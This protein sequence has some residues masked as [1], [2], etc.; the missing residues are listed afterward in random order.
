MR[1]FTDISPMWRI[2]ALTEVFGPSGFG[3]KTEIVD[4]TTQPGPSGDLMCFMTINLYV[5][6]DWEN[7]ES[8]WSDPILGFG[9][10]FLIVKES[11][12]TRSDDEG[13]KKAYTDAISVACKALGVGAAIYWNGDP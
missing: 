2:R 12:G 5:K 9:G 4:M 7:P 6:E 13:W 1:G 11:S 8:K 10:S 3:W